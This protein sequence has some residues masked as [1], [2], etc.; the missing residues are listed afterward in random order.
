EKN[1]TITG[2]FNPFLA[3]EMVVCIIDVAELGADIAKSCL[4][5]DRDTIAHFPAGSAIVDEVNEQY[6]ISWDTGRP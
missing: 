3:P 1:P 5:E 6:S 2:D 4:E